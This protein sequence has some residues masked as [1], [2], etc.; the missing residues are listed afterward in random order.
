MHSEADTMK[1]YS[2]SLTVKTQTKYYPRNQW[3]C[4][5]LFHFYILKVCQWLLCLWCLC[6]PLPNTVLSAN[7]M[8]Y[9]S[10]GSILGR[11]ESNK[12]VKMNPNIV[13]YLSCHILGIFYSQRFRIWQ[14]EV[15]IWAFV[16]C[17]LW[18]R[19]VLHHLE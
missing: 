11:K 10:L 4:H 6:R 18:W 7:L 8:I 5:W 17:G 12:L 2:F 9:C 1:G 15:S 13:K 14:V 19:W 3:N 16:I